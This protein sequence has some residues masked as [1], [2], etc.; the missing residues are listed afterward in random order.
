MTPPVFEVASGAAVVKGTVATPSISALEIDGSVIRADAA[1]A[2][3][4]DRPNTSLRDYK[5]CTELS[6]SL[7]F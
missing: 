1:I 5:Y 3:A 2:A 6:L 4:A 7:S